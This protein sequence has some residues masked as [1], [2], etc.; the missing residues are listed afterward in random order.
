MA[1]VRVHVRSCQAGYRGLQP[2]A[3]LDRPRPEERRELF[4]GITSQQKYL[5]FRRGIVRDYQSANNRQL[6]GK[7]QVRDIE[8][9]Y[10]VPATS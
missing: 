3:Y 1:V 6:T 7:S 9:S 2:D 4:R 8:G 10:L 5:V